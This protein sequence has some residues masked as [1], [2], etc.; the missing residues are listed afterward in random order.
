M[1]S[2]SEPLPTGVPPISHSSTDGSSPEAG[3]F[4]DYAKEKKKE[5]A[6]KKHSAESRRF[7]RNS[8]KT[9]SKEPS[10]EMRKIH[11]SPQGELKLEYT[12]S[13]DSFSPK[14]K[15]LPPPSTPRSLRDERTKKGTMAPR[16]LKVGQPLIADLHMLNEKLMAENM[17]LRQMNDQ[18]TSKVCRYSLVEKENWSP[19][20][21]HYM[22]F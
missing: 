18:L 5:S 3:N 4:L 22:F 7:F 11:D 2:V 16:K 12:T 20:R 10:S 17:S 19:K 1:G 9:L 6:K 14:D 13:T 15:D 8:T 21:S